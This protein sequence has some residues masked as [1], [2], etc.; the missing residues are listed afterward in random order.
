MD[1]H[2]LKDLSI[3]DR[4]SVLQGEALAVEEQV[5]MRPLTEDEIGQKKDELVQ[6]SLLKAVIEE[7]LKNIKEEFK[8]RIE[9]LKDQIT[10]SLTAIKNKAIESKGQ[11]YR[12]PDYD[13]QMI[14]TV[15]VMGVVL[16]SRRMLPEE[17]QFRIQHAKAV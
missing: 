4:Q 1:V 7:E 3:D 8:A 2:K 12:L 13:N 16:S 9:P 14:H 6:A 17:R 10:D 11:V 5:Y 15:D